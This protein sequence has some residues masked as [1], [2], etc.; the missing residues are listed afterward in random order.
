LR[1]NRDSTE[2]QRTEVREEVQAL[3]FNSVQIPE[4]IRGSDKVVLGKGEI[5]GG[6]DETDQDESVDP[7]SGEHPP[8]RAFVVALC[9][10]LGLR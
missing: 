3:Y 10:H 4:R 1:G 2:S 9:S 7:W 6:E 8:L 5:G